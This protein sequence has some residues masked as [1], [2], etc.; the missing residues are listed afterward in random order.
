MWTR[1]FLL[2][3][4]AAPP[5][6]AAPAASEAVAATAPLLHLSG[7]IRARVESIDNQVR[8][9]LRRDEDLFVL[10]TVLR[11]ELGNGPLRFV[12]EIWDS[13]AY[14]S[15]SSLA[16]GRSAVSNGEVNVFEPVQVHVAADLGDVLG[17]GTALHVTAGRM[18]L[19]LGSRRLVAADDYRN[20][21]AGST[22]LRVDFRPRPGIETSLIYVLPQ[23]RLPNAPAAVQSNDFAF[24]RESFDL[25]LW[26]GVASFDRALGASSV[27]FG[28]FRLVERDGPGRPTRDRHLTTIA[29]RVLRPPAAGHADHDIEAAWQWGQVRN[30]LLGTAERQQVAAWFVH[31]EAGYSPMLAGHLRLAVEL[32]G[33]SGDRPGGR[34]T[35][36]DTLFGMRRADF[37]PGS[38]LSVIGRANMLAA[39]LR[40]EAAPS[41][42]TDA[43]VSARAL[44]AESGR[45]VFSQSGVIDTSGASGR[46]AGYELDSRLRHWLVPARLRA[47][48]D[49]VVLLRRGLLRTAPNAPAGASTLYASASLTA[50]F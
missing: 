26:G 41:P 12:T 36:F 14:G 20:T 16:G 10:R 32:D 3:L 42:R 35:R 40:L 38:I 19:N 22:G 37:S 24:D 50:Y 25:Q 4:L 34:Y 11:A 17:T 2:S 18:M 13:R 1:F 28:A 7:N 29:M 27:D 8:P 33:I 44:W 30:G 23:Q 21:T 5:A 47:E 6:A 46:F 39:G 31:A 45:D 9:G 43:F 15:G 49:G 48:I